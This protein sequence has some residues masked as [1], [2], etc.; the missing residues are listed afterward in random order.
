MLNPRPSA[1]RFRSARQATAWGLILVFT[2]I[3]YLRMGG[4]P[5]VLLDIPTRHFTLFGKTFLPTDTLPF[6]LL[7]VSI[8]VTVFLVTAI[9][10]RIWCGW[11][12]PQTVYMEF[13]YRPIQRLFEGT[14]GRRAKSWQGTGPAPCRGLQAV[15]SPQARPRPGPCDP[16]GSTAPAAPARS[17]A[18][19]GSAE[20]PA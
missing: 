4:K 9:L 10:G 16:R 3:P 13:V 15:T 1:G 8:F 12:C 17:A 19:S 2:A 11:A 6:A 14:P 5:L 20:L 18:S 7:V